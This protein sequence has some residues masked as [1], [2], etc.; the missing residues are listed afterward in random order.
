[1]RLI[2]VS[3]PDPHCDIGID[4]SFNVADLVSGNFSKKAMK[5]SMSWKPTGRVFTEIIED[6][7]GLNLIGT[8]GLSLWCETSSGDLVEISSASFNEGLLIG[9]AG[10]EVWRFMYRPK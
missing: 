9:R 1:M 6:V 3:T 5:N 10:K 8:C 2:R 7:A 4:G